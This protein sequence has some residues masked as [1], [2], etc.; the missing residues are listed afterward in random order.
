MNFT[1]D[2]ALFKKI[3]Y[4]MT[5]SE[6]ERYNIGTYKEK[7]LHLTLKNYFSAAVKNSQVEVPYLGHVADIVSDDGILEIQT[8]NFGAMKTKLD[9]FLPNIPVYIIYPVAEKKWL[10]WIDPNSG[11]ISPKHSSPKKGSPLNILPEMIYLRKYL[12]RDNLNFCAV[13]L[14]IEEYRYLDG[15]SKDKKSGSHRFDRIPVDIC[16][17]VTLTTKDDYLKLIPDPGV[18]PEPFTV[19]EFM[20]VSKMNHADAYRSIK[21]LA[22]LKVIEKG[23]KRGREDQYVISQK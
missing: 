1:A 23:N 18:L 2:R 5:V 10:S 20:K 21:V 11:E 19:K 12:G 3:S 8:G 13:M 6:H 4:E 14:E 16:S 22:D 9:A 7:K 15:W 17:I